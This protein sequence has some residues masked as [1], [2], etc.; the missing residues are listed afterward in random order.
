MEATIRN[1]KIFRKF[2]R[3]TPGLEMKLQYFKK[4][5]PVEV[6]SCEIR[7]IFKNTFYTEHLQWIPMYNDMTF[8]IIAL[9]QN[10][11]SVLT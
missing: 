8:L 6:F 2:L 10:L 5:T 9:K 3:K 1:F 7:I 11:L 4:E